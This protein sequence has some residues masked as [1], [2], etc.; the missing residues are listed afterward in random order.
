MQNSSYDPIFLEAAVHSGFAANCHH[1]Q[2]IPS[3]R[4]ACL[5]LSSPQILLQELALSPYACK[6]FSRLQGTSC[7]LIAQQALVPGSVAFLCLLCALGSAVALPRQV[8]RKMVCKPESDQR[9]CKIQ[10]GLSNVECSCVS[11]SRT[12][13]PSCEAQAACVN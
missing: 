11:H 3:C 1:A 4:I 6:A 10:H 2:W 12:D 13:L 8:H 7:Q 5:G 9:A